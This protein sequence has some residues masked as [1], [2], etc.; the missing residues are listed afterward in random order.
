MR[1]VWLSLLLGGSCCCAQ[2]LLSPAGIAYD[3]AGNLYV[4]DARRNQVMEVTLAGQ[5]LVVA[6]TGVQGFG[7]DGGDATRALLNAPQGVTV[8]TDGTIYVAD[9]GNARVRSVSGGT[10]RTLAGDGVQGFAGDG[11]DAL[12]ARMSRPVALAVANDGALLV[13]DNGNN[14]IRRL[15]SSILTTI[16]GSGVQGFGGDGGPAVAAMLDG[17]AGVAITADGRMVIADARNHRVRV[18]GADGMINTLAGSG[19]R[20]FAG[21]GGRATAASLNLPRGVAVMPDGS[22]VFADSDNQRLRRVDP[23]GTITTIAGTGAQG[24]GGQAVAG[25]SSSLD[26]PRGVALSRFGDAVFADGRNAKVRA[27]AQDAAVYDTASRATTVTLTA[28]SVT[29]GAGSVTATVGGE[30]PAPRGSVTLIEGPTEVGSGSLANGSVSLPANMSPGTHILT[31]RYRGDGVHLAAVSPALTLNLG[32]A[33]VTVGLSGPASAY[34][35]LP[36]TLTASVQP[37]ANGTPTGTVSFRENSVTIASASLAGGLASGVYL[38]PTAGSHSIVASYGG[39]ANF[40]AADSPAAAVTVGILPDFA[41]STAS[42]AQTVQGGAATSFT[43]QVSG[44]P[45]PFT[46]SVNFA[47]SGLPKGAT[48]TFSPNAVVPGSSS[49]PVTMTVQTVPLARLSRPDGVWVAFLVAGVCCLRR[50]RLAALMILLAGTAGC[51]DRKLLTESAPAQSFTLTVSGTST[52]L[53][54]AVVTHTV[55]VTLTVR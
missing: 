10:I 6:G 1:L 5:T 3:A 51:G 40:L 48:A 28:G 7:G 35:G 21:D 39:D 32:K 27:L 41:L 16:V 46:G 13:A 38:S 19:I 42:N 20:G 44:A 49:V 30:S 43:V 37:Q 25:A 53:V 2:G 34:A 17:P 31:A 11:G 14:R 8:A 26:G 15:T 36:M 9:T 18:V 33:P 29:Y 4:A 50:R 45:G 24:A 23:A 52:N 12:H 22:I 47:V 54:G 55:P